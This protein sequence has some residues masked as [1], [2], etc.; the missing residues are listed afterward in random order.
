MDAPVVTE[1]IQSDFNDIL[2][3]KEL[4][5]ILE[6]ETRAKMFE[7]YRLLEEKLG[8]SGA[9]QNVAHIIWQSLSES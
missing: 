5:K 7:N 3:Q 2:L 4:Q 8:G 6:T 9:S 1:L